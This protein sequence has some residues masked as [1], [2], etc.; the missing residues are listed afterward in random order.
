MSQAVI[1]KPFVSVP[2]S[3][4]RFPFL[5]PFYFLLLNLFGTAFILDFAF[6]L[7]FSFVFN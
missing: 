5:L 4:H 6:V 2:S 7:E 1:F 3:N